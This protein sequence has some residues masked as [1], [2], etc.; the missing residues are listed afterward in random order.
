M[1]EAEQRKQHRATEGKKQKSPLHCQTENDQPHKRKRDKSRL[2]I[3]DPVLHLH[4]TSCLIVPRN[5]K[6]AAQI[7]SKA[8]HPLH[9]FDRA[10]PKETA[11]DALLDEDLTLP[12]F[13]GLRE[14]RPAIDCGQPQCSAVRPT[15]Q[16]AKL[17]EGGFYSD[18]A[19]FAQPANRRPRTKNLTWTAPSRPVKNLLTEPGKS[20]DEMGPAALLFQG[21]RIAH[22]AR[23]WFACRQSCV[24]LLQSLRLTG[25]RSL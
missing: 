1:I 12:R 15:R 23:R 20:P 19:I 17:A 22:E 7:L 18:P 9:V 4:N 24:H 16:V 14:S 21:L 13:S 8:G 5:A 11:D 25:E 6:R 10:R 3:S 2:L